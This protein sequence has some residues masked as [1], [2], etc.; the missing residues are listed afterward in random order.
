MNYMRSFPVSW[1]MDFSSVF[2]ESKKTG[3]EAGKS[4]CKLKIN[5]P[6]SFFGETN[7]SLLILLLN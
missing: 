1:Y 4:I 2:E 6:G 5:L 7:K 3:A